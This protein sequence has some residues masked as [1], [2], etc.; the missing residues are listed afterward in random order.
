MRFAVCL[1]LAV[2]LLA[3]CGGGDSPSE[4][5]PVNVPFQRVNLTFAS[6]AE[7][8]YV[9]RTQA[10]FA[11]AWDAAP[12]IDPFSG[13]RLPA[14]PRPDVD[15]SRNMVV[16]IS[17]GR[18]ILCHH[19]TINS[20]TQVGTAFVVDYESDKEGASTLACVRP[21]YLADLVIV[22]NTATSVTF[23]LT[24]VPWPKP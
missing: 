16:G 7:G 24:K 10:E 6:Y 18:D 23:V 1:A 14:L 12:P 8:T 20:V 21:E 3:G 4:P 19:L 5:Q 9:L 17:Q 13:E 11:A 15:F 22:P 2:S